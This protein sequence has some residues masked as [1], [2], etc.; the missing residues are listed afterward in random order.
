MPSAPPPAI[1]KG[2]K[3]GKG[4]NKSTPPPAPLPVPANLPVEIGAYMD[5]S[6]QTYLAKFTVLFSTSMIPPKTCQTVNVNFNPNLASTAAVRNVRWGPFSN[7][8]ARYEP[9]VS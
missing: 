5:A 9:I 2:G 7:S 1:S 3:P 6:C 8:A 4:G